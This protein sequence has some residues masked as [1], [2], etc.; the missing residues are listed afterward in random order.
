MKKVIALVAAACATAGCLAACGS[1][2]AT[3]TQKTA[4]VSEKKLKVVTTIYP[5]YDWVKQILG[6]KAD[7]AEVT[8]L[9]NNGVDLHSYQPTA[10]DI[11]KISEADI[12][13][14]V[15]GESDKWVDN[16]I[17]SANNKK[18]VAVDLMKTLGESNIRGSC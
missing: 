17:K 15:G 2:P 16:V 3:D 7:K 12:F 11:M 14:Y 8:N 5:E 13:I 6:D 9:I 4:A 18:L 10:Q 1:K